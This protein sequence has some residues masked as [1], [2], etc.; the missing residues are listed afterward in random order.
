MQHQHLA[1]LSVPLLAIASGL[2]AAYLSYTLRSDASGENIR[3]LA[4]SVISSAMY[5]GCALLFWLGLK[6]FTAQLKFAYGMFCGSL[7]LFAFAELQLPISALVSPGGNAWITGGGVLIPI[8]L[9][10]GG[11]YAGIRAFAGLYGIK[12]PWSRPWLIALLAII[13]AVLAFMLPV[14]HASD[15]ADAAKGSNGIMGI[16]FVLFLASAMLIWQVKKLSTVSYAK[17]MLWLF[18]AMLSFVGVTIITITSLVFFGPNHPFM[19]SGGTIAGQAILALFLLKAAYE[20]NVLDLAITGMSDNP[21]TPPGPTASSSSGVSIIDIIIAAAHK[22]SSTSAVDPILDDL[23]I[24]TATMGPDKVLNSEDQA[25]M[26][27][28]Y[29]KLEYY[30]TEEEPIR[31]Y[32]K[33]ELRGLIRKELRIKESSLLDNL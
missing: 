28:T 18:M 33:E 13:A 21:A 29:H 11:M 9:A 14:G 2:L 31:R 25:L 12:G 19:A 32:T 10:I 23:R 8:L 20:F 24:V 1:A 4:F 6:N 15:T 5:I 26:E 7:V 17:A 27:D 22:A 30:L 3:A 16:I